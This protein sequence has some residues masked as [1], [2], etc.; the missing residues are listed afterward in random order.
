MKA[1]VATPQSLT[2]QQ[3]EPSASATETV[4]G[5]LYERRSH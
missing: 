4:I 2:Q 5:Q 3:M 1:L